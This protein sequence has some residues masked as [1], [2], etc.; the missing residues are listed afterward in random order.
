MSNGNV[1]PFCFVQAD[2]KEKNIKSNP[3][4]ASNNEI[5]NEKQPESEAQV[6]VLVRQHFCLRGMNISMECVSKQTREGR[7]L[8]WID[9]YN[10]SKDQIQAWKNNHAGFPKLTDKS[11]SNFG[12]SEILLNGILMP[13]AIGL[14]LLLTFATISWFY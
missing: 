7:K 5:L 2:Q 4:T 3:A 12:F 8:Q 10:N 1:Y 9:W 11:G 6:K 14:C 13:L